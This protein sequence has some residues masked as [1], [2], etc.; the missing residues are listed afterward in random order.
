LIEPPERSAVDV[1]VAALKDLKALEKN[2]EVTDLGH[3]LDDLNVHPTYAKL[4]ILGIIFQCL[5]PMVI[6]AA[7][8]GHMN[9]FVRPLNAEMAA[10]IKKSR[11]A[12]APEAA[13]IH[14]EYIQAF[15]AVREVEHEQGSYQ[16][17]RFAHK[18]W[19]NYGQF[20]SVLRETERI[21]DRLSRI[22]IPAGMDLG[23][24]LNVQTAGGRLGSASM[25]TNSDH[26]PLI[27]ALVT[28]CLS[29]HLAVKYSGR[30]S[31][32][33]KH[34]TIPVKPKEAKKTFSLRQVL[35]VFNYLW[36]MPNAPTVMYEVVNIRPLTAALFG[37][38]LE[39][40]A[41]DELILN[42]WATLNP[43][44]ETNRDK[45]LEDVVQLHKVFK[46]VGITPCPLSIRK[47]TFT[48]GS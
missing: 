13:N 44:T 36:S 42:D 3:I 23:T 20:K 25:N 33:T 45:T 16:A 1:A 22:R 9:I 17:A 11:K 2:E 39:R 30:T 26:L 18:R 43:E 14:Y 37:N 35:C 15:R 6:F 19:I 8:G 38:R 21:M 7:L 5:D 27:K 47:L 28:H 12:F 29:H 10:K 48:I 4:A 41:E 24:E 46:K 32:N 40:T 34:K 31:F